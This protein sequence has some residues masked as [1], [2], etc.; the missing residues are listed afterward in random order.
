M[1]LKSHTKVEEKLT[2]GLKY[3]MRNLLNFH[4]TTQKS[5]SF[6]SMGYFCPKFMR[7]ELKKYRGIIFHGTE[8]WC[9]IWI[10]PD[11]AVSMAWRSGWTFIRALKSL[12]TCA[13]MDSFCPMHI[14]FQLEQFT[15]T[16]CHDTEGW[17][18]I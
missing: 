6:T 1:T 18:K 12:K 16:M 14:M 13:L 11:L 5:K 7:F 3:G 2:C 17:C 4:P 9:K 8:Q 15:G 10:N